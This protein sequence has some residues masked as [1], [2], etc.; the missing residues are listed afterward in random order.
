LGSGRAGVHRGCAERH[1]NDFQAGILRSLEFISLGGT[2][3]RDFRQRIRQLVNDAVRLRILRTGFRMSRDPVR[4]KITVERPAGRMPSVWLGI[5][6]FGQAASD[7]SPVIK[8][9][10]DVTNLF[11]LHLGDATQG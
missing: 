8:D 5:G 9:A 1:P 11:W 10:R 7:H 2:D 4:A 6:L 3:N